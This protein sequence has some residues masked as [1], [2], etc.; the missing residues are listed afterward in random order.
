MKLAENHKGSFILI[1]ES[2]VVETVKIFLLNFDRDFDV[3]EETLGKNRFHMK[4]PL[5]KESL[6]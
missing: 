3:L 5:I 2:H 4:L 1:S 6:T